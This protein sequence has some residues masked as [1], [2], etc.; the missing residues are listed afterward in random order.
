M[1]GTTSSE[2]EELLKIELVRSMHGTDRGRSNK[3]CHVE[4]ELFHA[5]N[6]VNVNA[7]Q[8]NYGKGCSMHGTTSMERG[9]ITKNRIGPFHAWN[10]TR[11][12]Q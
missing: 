10:G 5:W 1:H 8:L 4:E 11:S 2:R 12:Q 7:K 3:V 9:R 6:S